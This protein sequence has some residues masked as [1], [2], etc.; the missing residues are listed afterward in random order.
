MRAKVADIEP[1]L[2][3]LLQGDVREALLMEAAQGY[4]REALLMEAAVNLAV[5][6][7]EQ[8]RHRRNSS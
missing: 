5:L 7:R 8:A 4:V 1:H 2:W 3:S 6:M